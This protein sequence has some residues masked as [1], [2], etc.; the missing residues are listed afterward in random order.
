VLHG[1]AG[2]KEVEQFKI[3]HWIRL[4]NLARDPPLPRRCTSLATNKTSLPLLLKEKSTTKPKPAGSGLPF[5]TIKTRHACLV[6]PT[7]ERDREGDGLDRPRPMP[8]AT[9]QN[10]Q[11]LGHKEEEMGPSRI[12]VLCQLTSCCLPVWY[13]GRVCLFISYIHCYVD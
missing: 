4:W 12:P 1:I 2:G 11:R 5:L 13:S 3:Y 10:N 8:D 6:G 9:Q 7:R